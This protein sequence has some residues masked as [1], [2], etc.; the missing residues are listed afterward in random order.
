MAE[1]ANTC[2]LEP[3]QRTTIEATT[4]MRSMME[5]GFR[6]KRSR[7]QMPTYLLRQP[8]DQRRTTYSVPKNTTRTISIQKRVP[9]AR[10]TYCSMVDSTLK[11]RQTR[12]MR[13]TAKW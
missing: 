4:T 8:A 1:V 12:T 7:P 3:T 11:M 13:K 5:M 10:A 6:A 2:P 9:V